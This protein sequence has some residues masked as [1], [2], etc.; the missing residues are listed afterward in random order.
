MT[1]KVLNRRAGFPRL[2]V[3]KSKHDFENFMKRK[4]TTMD[5][6]YVESKLD[7]LRKGHANVMAKIQETQRA[8]DKFAADK[9][10][11]EGAIQMLEI[12]LREN[13]PVS[14]SDNVVQ[15]NPEA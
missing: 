11:T 14:E 6:A 13:P 3:F 1:S 12:M 15:M 10:A 5:R 8:L 2:P 7:A 9:I 4:V